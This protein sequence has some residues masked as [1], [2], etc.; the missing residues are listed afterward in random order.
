MNG[1]TPARYAPAIVGVQPD[2][3]PALGKGV[4]GMIDI[5]TDTV[6]KNSM[7]PVG[8][9]ALWAGMQSMGQFAKGDP[10]LATGI[11]AGAV[12]AGLS[13]YTAKMIA[14][15]TTEA[16]VAGAKEIYGELSDF[17]M[18]GVFIDTA[19]IIVTEGGSATAKP[20]SQRTAECQATFKTVVGG[21]GPSLKMMPTDVFMFAAVTKAEEAANEQHN[22]AFIRDQD[23]LAPYAG[24]IRGHNN[25]DLTY[26]LRRLEEPAKPNKHAEQAWPNMGL[27]AAERSVLRKLRLGMS[28][29][30]KR[31]KWV[32]PNPN[33]SSGQEFTDQPTDGGTGL[34]PLYIDILWH[35]WRDGRLPYDYLLWRSTYGMQP[36][37]DN[38]YAFYS[39]IHKAGLASTINN[40]PAGQAAVDAH[41]AD[42]DAGN[43]IPCPL[44]DNRAVMQLTK[45]LQGW[46]QYVDP[47]YNAQF[48]NAQAANNPF[49]APSVSTFQ[50]SIGKQ[51]LVSLAGLAILG[52]LGATGLYVFQPALAKSL[53][54]GATAYGGRVATGARLGANAVASGVSK[55]VSRVTG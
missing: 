33:S 50:R 36:H 3:M 44:L 47:Q 13:Y 46:D 26:L 20:Q 17:P 5:G 2:E 49:H 11:A 6:L 32:W 10:T 21:T 52:A 24:S 55:A 4:D 19:I 35:A 48:Q 51:P 41:Y 23:G 29:M 16:A 54:A 1:W 22:A 14:E 43:T 31:P 12:L 27:T 40:V 15:K 28:A 42:S 34:W 7:S 25:A 53:L 37:E 38:Y 30:Y 9:A 45:M 39:A 18:L 8:S